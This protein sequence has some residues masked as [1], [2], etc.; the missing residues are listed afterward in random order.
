MYDACEQLMRW[1]FSAA[2]IVRSETDAISASCNCVH[3]RLNRKS[4]IVHP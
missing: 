3:P 1:F 4:R 2:R